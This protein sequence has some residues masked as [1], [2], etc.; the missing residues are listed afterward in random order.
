VSVSNIASQNEIDTADLMGRLGRFVLR[1]NLIATAEI[2]LIGGAVWLA[3]ML[4][5]MTADSFSE[6]SAT[7]R[8]LC[9]RGSLLAAFAVVTACSIRTV[10]NTSKRRLAHEIDASQG[11]G[12]QI[13]TGWDLLRN[14]HAFDSPLTAKFAKQAIRQSAQRLSTITPSAVVPLKAIQWPAYSMLGLILFIAIIALV[15]P[16]LAWIQFK[17]F[18][19]PSLETT[20]FTGVTITLEKTQH[21][22]RYGDDVKIIATVS[23][24][25]TQRLE[26]VT[27]AKDG[28]ELV[29][30]MLP[31]GESKWQALLTDVKESAQF[32][33]RSGRTQS[34]M[35]M[36]DVQLT[37]KITEAVVRITP[38]EYTRQAVYEGKIPDSGIT[39]LVGTKVEFCVTSNRPLKLGRMQLSYDDKSESTVDLSVNSSES[40]QDNSVSCSLLLEREGSFEIKV[41]D[42][43]GLQSTESV[44]GKI[45]M[46]TDQRPIVRILE[47]KPLSLATPDIDLP[48]SISA[49]DDFG[50]S[51]LRLYR[52]LN[53]SAARPVELPFEPSARANVVV[54]LPLNRFG[55]VPGD[56]IDMFARTEDNDPSGPK[57]AESPK[58]TIRIISIEEFQERML[59]QRGA[60]ALS[61]KY[62]AAQRQLE[63][64]STAIAEAKEAADRAA[65]D[66]TNEALQQELQEKLKAAEEAAQAAAKGI[67]K[68]AQN[69]LDIDIDREL[70]EMLSEMA[71]EAQETAK[72][73]SEM[74]QSQAGEKPLTKSELEKL[75]ELREKTKEDRDQLQEEAIDPLNELSKTLP[76]MEDKERFEELVERQKELAQRMQSLA[77]ADAN[78]PS[79]ERRMMEMEAAQDALLQELNELSEDMA[80]N[81]EQ[82]PE[83]DEFSPLKETAMKLA[84]DIKQSGAP[85]LMNDAQKSLLKSKYKVAAENARAAA[86]SLDALQPENKSMGN[87]VES[88]LNGAFPKPGKGGKSKLGKTLEQLKQRMNQKGQKP[89]QGQGGSQPGEPGGRNNGFSARSPRQLNMGMYGSMPTPS[90][91]SQGR[92]DKVSQGAATQSAI[93]KQGTGQ[94]GTSES[95][96][97]EAS[98]QSQQNVP[99]QYRQ[100]VSEYYRRIKEQLKSK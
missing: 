13:M 46:L 30:P 77:D 85:E 32:F 3:F 97:S 66:P 61:A 29:L 70:S 68:L 79:N 42:I 41:T 49:E 78:D 23:K 10:R 55:L 31:R 58:T 73:L 44:Q 8:W 54:P 53:G 71:R 98:G 26:L 99:T 2:V 74:A 5:A 47:P 81:A 65:A 84:Q 19:Y 6:M 14:L 9:G 80:E 1:S 35:G 51:Q 69:P 39:G 36:L 88:S 91:S 95:Q 12:G 33:A 48:V 56:E 57:G 64:V 27:I 25:V 20:P 96:S 62:E 82:L 15:S 40:D 60:E 18:A 45:V 37:P 7:T 43:D 87:Q 17:R 16:P 75:N 89:G 92:S 11:T 76:L 72:Q 28:K 52:S 67:D 94:S 34:E 50:I 59:E 100:R 90:P 24:K 93:S 21:S 86:E 22:L 83:T 4:L 38:L 63:N